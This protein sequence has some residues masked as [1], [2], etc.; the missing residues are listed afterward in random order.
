MTQT[1]PT[2]P[3]FLF[4]ADCGVCQNAT[5]AIRAKVAPPVDIVAYRSRDHRSLGVSDDDLAAGPVFVDVDGSHVVGPLG[6]ARVLRLARQPYRTV[7]SV[8]LLPGVRHAIGVVGPVMYR[9]RHR[10]PGATPA[11][12]VNAGR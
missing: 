8:M 11:C 2:R 5:D 3:M 4:D 12:E 10:L 7:G 1:R 9:N 6:M